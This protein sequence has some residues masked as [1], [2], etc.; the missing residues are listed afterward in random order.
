MID[1]KVM[2]AE[3]IALRAGQ[4]VKIEG[5]L[6]QF[7]DKEKLHAELP[8]G[9]TGAARNLWLQRNAKVMGYVPV[10]RE[11]MEPVISKLSTKQSVSVFEPLAPHVSK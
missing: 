5:V 8:E 7:T 9:M 3:A 4:Q 1:N 10:Y 6:V 2:T 11:E